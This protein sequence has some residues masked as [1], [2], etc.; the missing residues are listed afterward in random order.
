[1]IDD[2]LHVDDCVVQEGDTSNKLQVYW[3]EARATGTLEN[4]GEAAKKVY[5]LFVLYD[6]NGN[7]ILSS[8]RAES[9]LAAGEK[10]PFKHIFGTGVYKLPEYDHIKIYLMK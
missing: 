10:R 2:T 4:D 6:K 9:K 5:L 3:K 7:I 8:Q 1:M